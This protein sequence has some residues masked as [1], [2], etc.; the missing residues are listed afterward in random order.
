MHFFADIYGYDR[1]LEATLAKG[2][3]Y[4]EAP[5]KVNSKL[6]LGDTD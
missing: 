2:R 1:E 5:V 6:P 4:E 3:T